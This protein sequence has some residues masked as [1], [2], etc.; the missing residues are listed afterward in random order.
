MLLWLEVAETTATPV[1]DVTNEVAIV[2]DDNEVAVA[3]VVLETLDTLETLDVLE[4]VDAVEAVAEAE[5]D[6]EEEVRP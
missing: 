3:S 6:E 4:A 5:A 2:L 1:A